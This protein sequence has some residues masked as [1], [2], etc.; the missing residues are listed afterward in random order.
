MKMGNGKRIDAKIVYSVCHEHFLQ[1]E[2]ESYFI[3]FWLH[4]TSN[5]NGK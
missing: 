5:G 4:L 2:E 3:I 1:S